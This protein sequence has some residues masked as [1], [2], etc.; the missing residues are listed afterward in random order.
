MTNEQITIKQRL[1]NQRR[2]QW[3]I[4]LINEYVDY[5]EQEVSD[6]VKDLLNDLDNI[7]EEHSS[8]QRSEI[9]ER[10][11]DFKDDLIDWRNGNYLDADDL[12]EMMK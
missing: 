5:K 8:K 3:A 1:L 12:S 10:I 2:P 11:R 7:I 4:N 6:K 9:K